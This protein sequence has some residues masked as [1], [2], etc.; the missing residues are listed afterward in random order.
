MME[1]W[2][3][4]TEWVIHKIETEYKDDIALLVAVKGQCTD[5]DGHGECFDYFIPRTERGYELGQSFMIHGIGCDLYPRSW[6]RMEQTANLDEMTITL[7]GARILYAGS[8][9]EEKRFLE[10]Q[11]KLEQNLKNPLFTYQKALQKLDYAMDLYRT[12]MFEEKLYRA[13]MAAIHIQLYLTQAVAFLNGTYTE[14]ALLTERQRILAVPEE[15]MYQCPGLTELPEHFQQIGSML[16]KASEIGELQK[17]AK[18][19]ITAVRQFIREHRPEPVPTGQQECPV[20]EILAGWYQEMSLTWRRIRYFCLNN[21]KEEALLDASN[22]QS[23]LIIVAKEFQFEEMDLL[24]W[25]DGENLDKLA[26]RSTEL[27][28]RVRQIIEER[29]VKIREYET[30]DKF[31]ADEMG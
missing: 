9:E 1:N 20:D 27:E 16:T 2:N 18:E 25:Y 22:L 7:A 21:R 10:L 31:L 8:E 3:R 17:I 12:L 6:E 11:K 29:G 23:E 26:K 14:T 15:R 28:N 13:R 24:G 19:L 30:M 5:G 4:L